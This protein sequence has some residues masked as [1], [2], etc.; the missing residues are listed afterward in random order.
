MCKR[1]IHG[2][3]VGKHL[4]ESPLG[5]DIVC[6][7][8]AKAKRKE[9]EEDDDEEEDAEVVTASVGDT[10]YI[11]TSLMVWQ[12]GEKCSY[13]K[14]RG[15][16]CI[17]DN[18]TADEVVFCSSNGCTSKSHLVCYLNFLGEHCSNCIYIFIFYFISISSYCFFF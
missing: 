18:S 12:P 10:T 8:C 15:Y 7:D 3:C 14:N 2:V 1:P 5:R 16:K 4:E 13:K 17:H 11:L 9:E 6:F